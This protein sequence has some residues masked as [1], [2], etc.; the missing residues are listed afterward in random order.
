MAFIARWGAL[1]KHSLRH[2][3]VVTG[4]RKLE[5]VGIFAFYSV[6]EAEEVCVTS[7]PRHRDCGQTQVYS[8]SPHKHQD[9]TAIP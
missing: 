7:L 6:P 5:E 9:D 4:E 3:K 8:V 2:C 1:V